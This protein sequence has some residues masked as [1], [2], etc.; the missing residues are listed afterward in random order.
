MGLLV[1]VVVVVVGGISA[2]GA[3]DGA[4]FSGGDVEPMLWVE[5][6][7]FESAIPL[8]SGCLDVLCVE[9]AREVG[10]FGFVFELE[11]D[12]VHGRVS[13]LG[14]EEL[15]LEGLAELVAALVG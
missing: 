12:V 9:L 7:V 10:L 8:D 4:T 6:G 2:Q 15:V 5:V 13:E 14:Y 11:D 1:V 3:L